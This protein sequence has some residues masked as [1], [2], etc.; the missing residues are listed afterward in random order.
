M[1]KRMDPLPFLSPTDAPERKKEKGHTLGVAAVA[2]SRGDA[3]GSVMVAA[4]V[5]FA[6]DYII[7]I[8]KPYSVCKYLTTHHQI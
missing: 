6:G 7:D 8:F 2:R 5:G 4:R 1:G 3:A